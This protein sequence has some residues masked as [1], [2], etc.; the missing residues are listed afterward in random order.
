MSFIQLIDV[1]HI[2][3]DLTHV[4]TNCMIFRKVTLENNE[5]QIWVHIK[6]ISKPKN[7]QL[8]FKNKKKK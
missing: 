7:I 6:M 8:K 3:T 1:T 2:D 5:N 4:I